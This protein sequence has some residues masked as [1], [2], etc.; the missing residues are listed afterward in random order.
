[1]GSETNVNQFLRVFL[2]TVVIDNPMFVDYL[3]HWLAIVGMVQVPN[4]R[5]SQY[6]AAIR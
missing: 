2:P 5:Q 3:C 6:N 4:S 1:M